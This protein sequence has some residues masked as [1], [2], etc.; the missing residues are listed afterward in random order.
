LIHFIGKDILYFHALFWPAT[1]NYSNYRTP[2]KIFTHG[3]LT[4]NGEKMS[5]SRGT[6]IT[7]RSYLDHVKDPNFLRYYYATKLNS[8]MEDLDLNL[9]DFVAK[10]NSDL[11]GKFINI[12]SRT[13]GFLGKFFNH[14]LMPLTLIAS[15]EGL[16]LLKKI[17]ESR[18]AIEEHYE[19]R[20]FSKLVKFVMQLIEDLNEYIS[21]TEPWK[22][23]KQEQQQKPHSALH[24]ICS[25]CL[26][27]FRILSIFLTP[28]IPNLCEK[29]AL[30]YG[31]EFFDSFNLIEDDVLKIKTYKHLL[32]R[33][34]QES[35]D[36]MINS[37]SK[38]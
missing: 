19:A 14:E 18:V 26:K 9:E 25:I 33:I 20:E 37:N 6:F 17:K 31:E 35:V 22:L 24:E 13:S 10:N 34:E 8:S 36:L 15:D 27:S 21:K 32:K 7:A 30:F 3:F 4:V 28:I 12:P 5:K 1:L 2:T 38:D 16:A 23:A 11:I 29:I